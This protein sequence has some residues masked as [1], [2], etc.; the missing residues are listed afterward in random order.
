MPELPEVEVICRGLRP[1]LIGQM[2]TQVFYNQK[3]LRK[4]VDIVNIRKEVILQTIVAVERRAK[5]ILIHMNSGAVLIIHL[6]MTGNLGIFSKHTPLAKHDHLQWLLGDENQLRYHDIR[7]FG[8]IHILSPV[9]AKEREKTFFT[10]SGPEPFDDRF[11][12]DYLYN[13]SKG[14]SLTIKQCIMDSKIVVGI[15]NIYA[16]ESLFRA[17]ISP[18]KKISSLTK[19]QWQHLIATIRKVL[20]HAIDCGGSTISDFVNAS[21]QQGYFQMNFTVYGKDGQPCPHCCAPL[22]KSKLG[23]RATFY[24]KHCQK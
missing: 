13:L 12:P 5:Y 1:H 11:S 15:G 7:R 21:Q 9:E 22:L 24:C 19:P 18:E 4:P 17:G 8:S 23:G 16:N 20:D 14:K 6:G 3:S 2:I 10:T